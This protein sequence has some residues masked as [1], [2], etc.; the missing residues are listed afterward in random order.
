[1]RSKRSKSHV[2]PGNVRELANVIEHATILCDNGPIS[3]EHL[4]AQFSR[5]QLTGAAANRPGPITLRDL[6]MQAIYQVARTARRQQAAGGRRARHQ[7]QDALQQNQRGDG[8]GKVGLALRRVNSRFGCISCDHLRLRVSA[9][10]FCARCESRFFIAKL[11]GF[12][13]AAGREVHKNVGFSL[14]G[15]SKTRG[16]LRWTEPVRAGDW[17]LKAGASGLGLGLFVVGLRVARRSAA[18]IGVC[19]RSSRRRLTADCCSMGA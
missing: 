13:S 10:V 18:L 3:A 8:A 15:R 6:E 1:M 2:W 14:N 19:R 12:A 11:L 5:R 17:G 7:P 4:P 9:V 16:I